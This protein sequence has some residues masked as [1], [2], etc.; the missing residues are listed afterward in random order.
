M[1]A[2][3]KP[4]GDATAGVQPIP[5]VRQY[6]QDA[7]QGPVTSTVE[8]ISAYDSGTIIGTVPPGQAGLKLVSGVQQRAASILSDG[9]PGATGNALTCRS[10]QGV[11][12]T[13]PTGSQPADG[14]SLAPNHE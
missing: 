13:A 12:P 4:A 11:L 2:I 6:Y 7:V 9:T 8:T 5:V 10:G 3:L 1:A 14:L